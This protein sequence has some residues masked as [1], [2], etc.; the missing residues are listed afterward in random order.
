[1]FTAV[2]L[3]AQELGLD[4]LRVLLDLAESDPTEALQ[5]MEKIAT[6]KRHI[7]VF[8]NGAEP[9]DYHEDKFVTSAYGNFTTRL[10]TYQKHIDTICIGQ[11]DDEIAIVAGTAMLSHHEQETNVLPTNHSAT[12]TASV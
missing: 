5:A 11:R 6:V 9:D 7:R 10:A 1:L 8:T 3:Y 12:K 2:G 4:P